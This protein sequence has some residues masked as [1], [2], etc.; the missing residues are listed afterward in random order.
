MIKAEKQQAENK[1]KWVQ[2]QI[3]MQNETVEVEDTT[4]SFG[5]KKKTGRD[6]LML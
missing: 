5:N 1:L 3:E 2:F 6:S 4:L